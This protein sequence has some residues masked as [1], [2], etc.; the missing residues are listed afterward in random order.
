M[1]NCKKLQ[2]NYFRTRPTN[3]PSCLL[4]RVNEHPYILDGPTSDVV[5]KCNNLAVV[6]STAPVDV[7]AIE[8]SKDT[9]IGIT[10]I[11]HLNLSLNSFLLKCF[12]KNVS[13]LNVGV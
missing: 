9:A 10:P 12:N 7:E 5:D 1:N 3:I 13:L 11:L 8:D 4:V 6:S 2:A